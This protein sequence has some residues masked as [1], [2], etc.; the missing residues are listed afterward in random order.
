[1]NITDFKKMKQSGSSIKMITCYDSWTAKI[2]ATTNVDCLLVGDS[3]AMVMH[4]HDTTIPAEVDMLVAHT[5]AVKRGAPNKLIIGDLPFLSYRGSISDTMKNVAKLMRAGASA[6]KLEGVIGNET[7]IPHLTASG[8]PVIGHIGFTPQSIHMFGNSYVQGKNQHQ[9]DEL[10]N[11]A[12][13]LEELGC[14]AIVLECIPAT[15]AEEI[16]TSLTIPTIGIGAGIKTSGQ[17]LVLQD[18]LGTDPDFNPKFLKKYAD[19]FSTIE[20]AVN[21]YC[22]EVDNKIFP[23]PEHCYHKNAN[24]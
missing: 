9:A 20:D 18:L 14:I 15:L 8:V 12:K 6:I 4:G 7:I 22:L 13:T 11:A 24:N 1:M 17:V 3:A 19:L 23:A 10:K 2:L 16:T 21:M 5:E